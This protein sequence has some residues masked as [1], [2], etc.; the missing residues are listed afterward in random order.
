MALPDTEALYAKLEADGLEKVEENLAAGIYGES[1]RPL[2][3]HWIQSKRYGVSLR[4][5]KVTTVIASL[6]MIAAAVAAV[7]AVLALGKCA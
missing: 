6:A 5:W 1:K 2:V 3:Q 7:A 4:R